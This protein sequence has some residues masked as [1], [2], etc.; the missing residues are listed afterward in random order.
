MGL[1]AASLPN[2]PLIPSGSIPLFWRLVEALTAGRTGGNLGFHQVE[3][4]RWK[5]VTEQALSHSLKKSQDSSLDLRDARD[6][7]KAFFRSALHIQKAKAS[8]MT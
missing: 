6:C 2:E 8:G 3:T 5:K 4:N 1:L 7:P